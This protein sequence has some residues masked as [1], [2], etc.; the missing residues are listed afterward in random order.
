MPGTTLAI[1]E[2]VPS[3]LVTLPSQR[4]E[5]LWTVQ[6]IQLVMEQ[7]TYQILVILPAVCCTL[8]TY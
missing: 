8:Q 3:A 7:L 5:M 4:S 2:L 1:E 6:L